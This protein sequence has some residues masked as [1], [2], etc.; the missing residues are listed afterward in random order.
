[1]RRSLT[2]LPNRRINAAFVVLAA[3]LAAVTLLS[4]PLTGGVLWLR[5]HVRRFGAGSFELRKRGFVPINATGGPIQAELLAAAQA[6]ADRQGAFMF[7]V[8]TLH[9]RP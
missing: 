8:L 3:S 7:T 4:T 1:M 5:T 6:A 9:P 2:Q